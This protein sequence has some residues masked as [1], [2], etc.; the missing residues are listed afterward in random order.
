MCRIPWFFNSEYHCWR[1]ISET[2]KK[3]ILTVKQ[4]CQWELKNCASYLKNIAGEIRNTNVWYNVNIVSALD[5]QITYYVQYQFHKVF[6]S[7]LIHKVF[8]SVLI[9]K[10]FPSVLIHKVFPSVLIHKA[11]PSVLTKVGRERGGEGF[12]RHALLTQP[13]LLQLFNMLKMPLREIWSWLWSL[14]LG[15]TFCRC[16]EARNFN[17]FST[18][19][20]RFTKDCLSKQLD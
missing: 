13:F 10:A 4:S 7:V 14:N 5:F 8:P 12:Q 11:F 15:E 16:L 17:V 2:K 18:I 19:L 1:I 6:P 9:Y 3:I 20:G